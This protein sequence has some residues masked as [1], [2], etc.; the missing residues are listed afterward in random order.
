MKVN[1]LKA[2][3]V[4]S[5]L[6]IFI[7]MVVALLYTPIMLRLLGQSEYGLYSLIG[8]VVGYLSILDLGLGSA[9]IRYN[10]RNRALGDKDAESRLN[11]MFLVLYSGIG[12]ITVIIGAVLYFNVENLFGARLTA[13]ELGKG[14]IM[15]LLLICN[16]AVSFPLSIFG[17][18]M[19]AYEKFVFVKLV[20]I[21]NSI[22]SPCIMLPF[23]YAGF[24][25]VSMVVVSTVLNIAVLL[26]NLGY[27]VRVL[28]IRIHFEGFDYPLLGEIAGYSFFIFLTV[29][30]DKVYWSTGQVI[31]GIV[32]FYS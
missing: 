24:G 13:V 4:L 27:C 3:V 8:S 26:I 5:Y 18:I 19:Q 2:G 9:M 21:I 12:I 16:F 10:A 29:I 7:T 30:V 32:V 17:S 25:S 31:L 22:L 15:M 23:L 6:S 14:R 20:A 1:E 11:G 28:K